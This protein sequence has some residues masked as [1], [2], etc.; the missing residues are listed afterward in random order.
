RVAI[1][2]SDRIA[3]PEAD[4]G[5]Q[6]LAARGVDHP[7]AVLVLVKDD[8]VSRMHDLHREADDAG[9]VV[10]LAMPDLILVAVG[11]LTP[12]VA[13]GER[14]RLIR[15][16]AVFRIDDERAAGL[17]PEAAWMLLEDDGV[18][19]HAAPAVPAPGQV[20]FA[21]GSAWCRPR[22]SGGVG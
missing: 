8:G 13:L 2:S 3:Q 19:Q 10:E 5:R 15:D 22:R 7:R 1:P 9:D 16:D 14:P 20:G 11:I 17:D 18:V 12:P 6:V 4:A 21:V